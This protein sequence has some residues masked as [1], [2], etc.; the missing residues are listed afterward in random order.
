MDF[1]LT[2]DGDLYL[3][4]QLT[5]KEGYFLYYIVDELGENLP[6]ITRDVNEATIPIRDF[7][8]ISEDLERLQLIKTR[9]QTENPDWAL[10]ESVG[11]S[12]TDFIGEKNNPTTGSLI[13]D[14]VLQTLLRNDAFHEEELSVNVIPISYNEVLVDVTLDS[15]SMYLR[16]AF[17][18]NFE[19]G[20]NN[21]YILDRN[22]DIVEE[23][24]KLNPEIMEGMP[25][26]DILTYEDLEDLED[27]D[28]TEEG[29][30]I[31]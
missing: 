20:V 6:I 29:E 11:A 30:G 21:V 8:L 26:E 12:L 13:E 3:G 14:R 5:D 31:E 23:E 4:Q 9:L 16:Y 25:T 17:S 28:N 22:G 27:Y 19:I 15:Q 2:D 7:K 10:Y 1:E 18:L 24:V